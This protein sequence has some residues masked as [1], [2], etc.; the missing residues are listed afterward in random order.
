VRKNIR[1][2]DVAALYHLDKPTG[3]ASHLLT[4]ITGE[5]MQ[6]TQT[7]KLSIL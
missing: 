1:S 4:L 2:S 3:L 5:E 6:S 7:R